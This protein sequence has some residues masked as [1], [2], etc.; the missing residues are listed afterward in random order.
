MP[1][2]F[3]FLLILLI[4]NDSRIGV[5]FQ[6]NYFFLIFAFTVLLFLVS[7]SIKCTYN[8]SLNLTRRRFRV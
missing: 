4:M 2:C 5:T 8:F 6:I 3:S 7:Y 1:K